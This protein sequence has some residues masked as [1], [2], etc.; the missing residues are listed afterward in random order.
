MDLLHALGTFVRVAET[1]SLS[2][3]ARETNSSHSSITRAIGQ[4]EDHFGMRLFHRT[5]RHLGL[6]DDGETLL[7]QARGMLEAAEE[8]EATLGRRKASPTGRVRVALPPAMAILITPRLSTLLRRYPGLFVDLVIGERFG[9]VIEERLDLVVQN[10]RPENTSAVARAIATFSRAVVAAP[11]YLQEHGIPQIPSELAKH[12]CIVHETGADSDRW[13]FTSPNGQADVQVQG[14]LHASSST[15]VHRA[16][17]AGYG[18]ASLP[19][20]HVL[21]DIRANRLCRLLP[22]WTSG[23]EQTFILYPSRR[24]VPPR[25]RVM[26]D[27]FVSV[28]HDAEAQFAN[29]R[30][31]ADDENG[32]LAGTRRAA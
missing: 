9:D 4:L 26:I 16:A 28:G 27:F 13:S 24:N 1:G 18:I 5:T 10:R 12:N 17:L 3:A 6:T 15:M 19:E 7:A 23:R 32:S 30:V 31:S 22:E 2:A 11:A 20:P 8:M 14:P 25:T 21:D 29:A